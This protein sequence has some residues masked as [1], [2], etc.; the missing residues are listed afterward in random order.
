M[1][2]WGTRLSQIQRKLQI[3]CSL[4]ECST[5]LVRDVI[6]MNLSQPTAV[7]PLIALAIVY[8]RLLNIQVCIDPPLGF[9]LA[10]GFGRTTLRL[11]LNRALSVWAC[12]YGCLCH[13]AGRYKWLWL[14][15]PMGSHF[16]WQVNSPPILGPFF[17]WG[18][19]SLGLTDLDFEKPMASHSFRAGD[20]QGPQVPGPAGTKWGP[21][22]YKVPLLSTLKQPHLG[23]PSRQSLQKSPPDYVVA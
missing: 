13:H 12:V 10:S 6:T 22:L 23:A 17:W 1:W 16:G 14:P 9:A 18:I 19:C 8:F 20:T 4:L 11:S 5:Y 3:L 2:T 15:K 7:V 21:H